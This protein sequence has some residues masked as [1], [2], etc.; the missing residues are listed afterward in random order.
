MFLPE[1]T[2]FQVLLLKKNESVNA[3][4]DNNYK[5]STCVIHNTKFKN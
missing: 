1:P 5:N 3:T 4:P 2:T